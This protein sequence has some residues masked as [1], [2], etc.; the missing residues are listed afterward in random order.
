MIDYCLRVMYLHTFYIK[1]LLYGTIGPNGH[2]QHHP[3]GWKTDR[4]GH[5]G[6]LFMDKK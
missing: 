5:G 4:H 2:G 1:A 3:A 6:T